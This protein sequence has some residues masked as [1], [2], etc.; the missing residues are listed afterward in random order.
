MVRQRKVLVGGTLAVLVIA[1][2][3]G[4]LLYGIHLGRPKPLDLG[5]AENWIVILDAN[6]ALDRDSPLVHVQVGVVS[7]IE[8]EDAL[9]TLRQ[10]RITISDKQ[11]VHTFMWRDAYAAGKC[12]LLDIDSNG[13]QEFLFSTFEGDDTY[14]RVVQFRG[15]KFQF[16]TDNDELRV[17]TVS[18]GP[19]HI[20]GKQD[21]EFIEKHSYPEG[22]SMA[23]VDVPRIMHWTAS[24]GFQDVSTSFPEYFR[25]QVL[26]DLRRRMSEEADLRSKQIFADAISTIERTVAGKLSKP[27]ASARAEN[28]GK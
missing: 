19:V 21:W 12:Q 3:W 9:H 20:E 16:R 23:Y 7:R 28:P 8:G 11:G 26:P 10:N 15:G 25:A 2:V 4:A 27:L 24:T 1:A 6:A 22:A 18:P 17:A 5:Y 13:V 14:I